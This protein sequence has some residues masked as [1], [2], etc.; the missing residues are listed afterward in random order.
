MKSL[1]KSNVMYWIIVCMASCLL[2]T[3]WSVAVKNLINGTTVV[4]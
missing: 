2:L 3:G 1:L 4:S